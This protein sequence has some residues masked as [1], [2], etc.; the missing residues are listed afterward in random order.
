M[1]GRLG[2]MM[3]LIKVPLEDDAVV[4]IVARPISQLLK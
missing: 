4:V 2:W 3:T 1:N